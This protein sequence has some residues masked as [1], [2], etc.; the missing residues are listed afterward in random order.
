MFKKQFDK[1]LYFLQFGYSSNDM[2][3]CRANNF[4]SDP[5]IQ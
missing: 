4:S 1:L 2:H 5:V 3:F